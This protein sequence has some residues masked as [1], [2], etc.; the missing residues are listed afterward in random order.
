MGGRGGISAKKKHVCVGGEK[1][2]PLSPSARFRLSGI[3]SLSMCHTHQ[4]EYIKKTLGGLVGWV[5]VGGAVKCVCECHGRWG[6]R[7]EGG[8][9]SKKATCV[10]LGEGHFILSLASVSLIVSLGICVTLSPIRTNQK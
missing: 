1:V 2:L 9:L 7:G 6:G 8:H 4:S 5:G 10:R 3:V